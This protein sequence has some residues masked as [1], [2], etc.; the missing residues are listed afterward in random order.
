MR[1][2]GSVKANWESTQQLPHCRRNNLKVMASILFLMEGA[3]L[4]WWGGRRWQ[5]SLISGTW[6]GE[7]W[8]TCWYWVIPWRWSEPWPGVEWFVTSWHVPNPPI[9][10]SHWRFHYLFVEGWAA[11]SSAIPLD[12]LQIGIAM[13]PQAT[14]VVFLLFIFIYYLHLFTLPLWGMQRS[15][16]QYFHVFH[17]HNKHLS[18][19]R[20]RPGLARL[21]FKTHTLSGSA[22]ESLLPVAP[23]V[24]RED[25]HLGLKP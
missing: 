8:E 5:V 25:K 13:G 19:L 2:P 10:S 12:C 7:T 23:V 14:R 18:A 16:L 1:K 6:L 21:S 24:S 4:T 11:P 20:A 22:G 15:E 17:L 9:K 3:G